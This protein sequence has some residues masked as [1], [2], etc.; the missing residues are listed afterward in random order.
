MGQV[1]QVS[2][3]AT[4]QSLE[5]IAGRIDPMK[6]PARHSQANRFN[7]LDLHDEG[8]V[9]VKI[10]PPSSRRNSTRIAFGLKD[11]SKGAMKEVSFQ[12]CA[13]FQFA[14]DFDVLAR[15]WHFGNLK[16]GSADSDVD[17][18]RNFVASHLQHWRTSYETPSPRNEPIKKK[19]ASIRG[20]T[21]FR[22]AFFGG[23]AIILAKG[24]RIKRS[25]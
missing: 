12:G 11:D 24:Y 21:L 15:N 1:D 13:N 18:M 17:R 22:L 20:Y 23:T 8:L 3:N 6:R 14:A 16:V 4:Y 9:S 7:N 5:V 25:G 2:A 10:H 19:L